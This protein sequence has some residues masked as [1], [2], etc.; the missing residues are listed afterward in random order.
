MAQTE[1]MADRHGRILAR[2]GELGLSLAEDLHRDAAAAET[3]EA[4]AL[5]AVAFHR[6][7][8]GLRQTLALEARLV[9]EAR[10]AEREDAAHARKD[11]DRAGAERQA[12]VRATVERLI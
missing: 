7:G 11:R 2:L 6:I 4:R 10:Q 9:R 3:P 12:Q 5:S 8:R 1:S